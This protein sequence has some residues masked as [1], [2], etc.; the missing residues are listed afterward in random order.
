LLKMEIIDICVNFG[1]LKI[2]FF[3]KIRIL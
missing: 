1:I 3:Y 2:I